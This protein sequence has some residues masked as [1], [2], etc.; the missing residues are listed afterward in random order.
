[1]SESLLDVSKLASTLSGL[2]MVAVAITA[3]V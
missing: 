1:M 2:P 3:S